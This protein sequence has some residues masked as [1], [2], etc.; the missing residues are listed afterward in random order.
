MHANHLLLTCA[1]VMFGFGLVC[2]SALSPAHDRKH[3]SKSI[4]E[5]AQ[6]DSAELVPPGRRSI[7]QPRRAEHGYINPTV[8]SLEWSCKL[9]AIEITI[10]EP[11]AAEVT[12][13]NP[14]ERLPFRFSPPARGFLVGSLQV[15]IRAQGEKDYRLID[16]LTRY[17]NK[18]PK[19]G[20]PV[21]LGP[22]EV[23]R[24]TS[25]LDHY[26]GVHRGTRWV[27][28]RLPYHRLYWLGD[29][30]FSKAGKYEVVLRYINQADGNTQGEYERFE[31]I[32]VRLFGPYPV[33]VKDRPA[34]DPKWVAEL[35]K[36]WD[37]DRPPPSDS[38]NM[39]S[40]EMVS[41]F[42]QL[43]AKELKQAGPIG[44]DVR[45]WLLAREWSSN[46]DE[47]DS[48]RRY[49]TSLE[50]AVA[51]LRGNHPNRQA[52]EILAIAAK[53]DRGDES[54]ALRDAL[55]SNNPDVQLLATEWLSMNLKK[56]K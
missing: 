1:S 4:E 23:R 48:L 15:W 43:S 27:D 16:G 6:F 20:L 14:A 7:E 36:A 49:L 32:G 34:T 18:Y 29:E 45:L 40:E 33:T 13:K 19:A 50:E 31:R 37:V 12:V 8:V 35:R 24:W 56:K 22:G 51:H 38:I 46:R 44:D 42:T 11:L 25:R 9:S 54:E 3:V 47:P 2:L 5:L 52:A 10:G 30:T 17:P 41:P 26:A 28:S 21:M 53:F 55:T 39:A